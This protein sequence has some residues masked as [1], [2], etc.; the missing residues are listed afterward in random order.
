MAFYVIKGS[1]HVVGYSPDGDSVKFMAD[2]PSKWSLLDG[3]SVALN[4][5]GHAQLRLESIDSLETH[6]QGE[7]QPLNLAFKAMKFLLKGLKITNVQLNANRTRVVSANDG[8]RGYIISRAVERNHRP[9]SFV[10]SG[11][12]DLPDWTPVFLDINRLKQSLN[13]K[14]IAAGMSY[15]TYYEGFFSDLRAAMNQASA[16]ARAAGF[17]IWARDR[18]NTGFAVPDLAAIEDT[19]VILPKL[20]RRLASFLDGGGVVSGFIDYLDSLNEDV[21]IVGSPNFP[22]THFTHFDTLIEIIGNVVR[23]TEMPEHLI[24]GEG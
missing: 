6:Y 16:Q 17:G 10:Y 21:A 2:D 11:E 14:S 12:P 19:H 3:S 24:F 15:P 9:I 7:H 18:T 8:K 22:G 5:R 23:L 1:F 4:G 20:F 13:Y